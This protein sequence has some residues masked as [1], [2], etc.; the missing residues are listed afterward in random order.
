MQRSLRAAAG[1]DPDE[2][3]GK[4]ADRDCFRLFRRLD[5]DLQIPIQ[6]MKHE[7]Q[8]ASFGEI[9]TYHV[10]PADYIRYFMSECP[11]MLCGEGQA[12]N[13]NL[14]SWWRLYAMHHPNHEIYQK[15]G[16]HLGFVIPAM[17]HGDEGRGL[18]ST[19][20]LVCSLESPIGINSRQASCQDPGC[21]CAQQMAGRND[22]PAFAGGPQ[23][24]DPRLLR[25]ARCME[26]NFKGQ[27]YLSRLL[28]FGIGGW[29]YKEQPH[30]ATRLFEVLAERMKSLFEDGILLPGGFR[31]YVAVVAV[32]GDMDFHRG[33]MALTRSYAHLGVV[34]NYAICHAC[35]AGQPPFFWEDF[36]DNPAWAQ[37]IWSTRPWDTT[38]PP[39]LS[40]IPF[41]PNAP[42]R[43]LQG[44]VFHIFK[45]GMG[46]NLV[47]GIV[48]LLARSGFW[49][50]PQASRNI[51]ARLKRCHSS[52]VLYCMAV[53][54]KP[55]LRSFT[56]SFFGVKSLSMSSPSANSK[57]SD[58]MLL[59]RW[60][61]WFC[62][63]QVIA[64][65]VPG[66]DLLLQGM[67]QTCQAGL[68]AFTLMHTHGLFLERECARYLYMLL[69]R[70]LRG[71]RWLGRQAL[72]RGKR[73]FNLTPKCHALHHCAFSLKTDLESGS[74]LVPNPQMYSCEINEDFLG[75]ISRLSRRVNIRVCDQ[76]V[77]MRYFL[78]VRA[79]KRRRFNLAS[80]GAT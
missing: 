57:G 12:W 66:H 75:R 38:C 45:V 79:L 76:K 16:S 61:L 74:V 55:G 9:T 7:C 56:K 59:L 52:F 58:T 33:I 47:G 36:R 51:K 6:E 68:D 30:I 13:A 26:T 31:V 14:E 44:D 73:G 60:L 4:N 34:A 64:P 24:V 15:H 10:D 3:D 39:A 5:L 18:K 46:R 19:N 71:Y 27:S 37:T 63:L 80:R 43:L 65:E 22:L 25:R 67:I 8:D 48:L 40:Q 42:E 2:V 78:K 20:Y 1:Q 70:L 28:L 17:I 49:D 21:N 29:V 35:M 69:L 77:I 62:K 41:N 50:Y 53:K 54:K 32:K 23:H 11:A 72:S